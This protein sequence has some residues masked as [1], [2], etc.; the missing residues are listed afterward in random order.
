MSY[1]W[2][3]PTAAAFYRVTVTRASFLFHQLCSTSERPDKDLLHLVS[4]IRPC[5]TIPRAVVSESQ[6]S[7][8]INII[9]A[10]VKNESS[11]PLQLRPRTADDSSGLKRLPGLVDRPM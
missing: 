9:T 1:L 3:A 11:C 5:W 4:V 10:Q 6:R 8:G 7:L 2:T